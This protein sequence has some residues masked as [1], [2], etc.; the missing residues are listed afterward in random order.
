LLAVPP[1]VLDDYLSAVAGAVIVG[2]VVARGDA[3]LVL[4]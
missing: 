4:E 2:S 1:S 3:L